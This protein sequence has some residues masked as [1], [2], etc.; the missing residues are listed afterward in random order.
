VKVPIHLTNE[1]KRARD[2]AILETLLHEVEVSCMP[3]NIPEAIVI[4]VSKLTIGGSVHVKD[5]QLPAGVKVLNP[6]E[7]SVLHAAAPTVGVETPTAA[8][9]PEVVADKKKEE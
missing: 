9:E 8:A 4:D 5:L 2:G 7:E 3:A 6:P 1:E